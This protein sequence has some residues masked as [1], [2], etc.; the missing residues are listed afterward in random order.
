MQALNAPDVGSNS[1]QILREFGQELKHTQNVPQ[2]P[3]KLNKVLTEAPINKIVAVIMRHALD[4]L[5]TDIHIEPG[6]EQLRIRYLIN[7]Q[8]H[9]SLLLPMSLHSAILSRIKMLSSMQITRSNTPQEGSIYLA[10]ESKPLTIQVLIMPTTRGEKI[11]MR[12][13]RVTKKPPSLSELG[14]KPYHQNLFSRALDNSDGLI[15][16]SGPE[17]SGKAT[18]LYSIVSI[19]NSP[20][21]NVAS[22]EDPVNYEVPGVCQ[23]QVHPEENFDYPDALHELYRQDTNII[24]I[25]KIN[26]P[27]MAQ[28]VVQGATAG[29]LILAA[30]PASDSLSIISRLTG[31]GVDPYLLSSSLRL[32][33]SQ[34]LLPKLCPACSQ[35]IPVPS[36]AQT[37]IKKHLKD[38]PPEYFTSLNVSNKIKIFESTGCPECQERK[39]SGQIVILEVVPIF[40]ELRQA[41]INR[42]PHDKMVQLARKHR[43]ISLLQDG[44]LKTLQGTVRY[45]DVMRAANQNPS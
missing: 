24:M 43:H 40:H 10:N 2:E 38:I 6:L 20:Q 16:T 14:V 30:L 32:L 27:Q 12:V 26:S 9:T 28:L 18:L 31:L 29:H 25:D 22:I 35:E 13:T 8:L 3:D 34:R 33:V 7:R 5:A 21:V 23:T 17:S 41:I 11:T 45:Q 36:Q 15:L 44:L 42:D 1:E 19:L 4:G 37:T 39:T